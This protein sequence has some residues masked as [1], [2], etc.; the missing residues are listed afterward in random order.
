M[1]KIAPTLKVF[2]RGLILV[3]APLALN[4]TIIG[5]LGYL[6][7]ES[8]REQAFESRYRNLTANSGNLFRLGYEAPLT[9]Y[10]ALQSQE[11]G[12]FKIYDQ[13][14]AL[15]KSQGFKNIEDWRLDPTLSAKTD[16]AKNHLQKLVD[17]LEGLSEARRT[18]GVF[19]LLSSL[20]N[21]SQRMQ[22]VKDGVLE[23]LAGMQELG[24]ARTRA[25]AQHQEAM[26]VAQIVILIL[27]GILNVVLGAVLFRFYKR[28]IKN[29]LETIHANTALLSKGLPMNPR[30]SGDDE[31]SQLD[32]A[33]HSMAAEL[34]ESSEREK[35]LFNNASDVIC[36]LDKQ[37]TFVKINPACF[38][39]WGFTPEELLQSSLQKL[40]CEA[41]LSPTE[42]AI[43]SAREQSI[44]VQFESKTVTK[45]GKILDTL[46]SVYWSN[47][48]ASLYCVV[49]D[50]TERKNAERIKKQFLSMITSDLKVPL[51]SIASAIHTLVTNL[52]GT[53]SE[54][55]KDKLS[56]A[57][58]NVQRLLSLVSDLLQLT[59]LDSGTL[60]LHKRSC[61]VNEILIRAAQDVEGVATKQQVA[62]EIQNSADQWI[63]DEDRIM[64]VL[65]NLLSN[66]IK[67]SPANSKVC[68]VASLEDEMVTVKVIDKGRGVP[69]AH[70]ELIFEKYK[71]VQA[72]DGKR[73]SGTGLGLPICKQIV[74]E[75][76]G[77]IGVDSVE[78]EGSTFWCKLPVKDK[79]PLQQT[80]PAMQ[81]TRHSTAGSIPRISRTPQND[82]AAPVARRGGRLKLS[83]KGALLIGAPTL[84]GVVF[85]AAISMLLFQA[86]Q[87]RARELH[88]RQIV[89]DSN[90]LLQ[91]YLK[92]GGALAGPKTPENWNHFITGVREARKIRADLA[93]L[94][95]G[96]P[97]AEEHYRKFEKSFK[98]PEEYYRRAEEIMA[99]GQITQDRLNK[100][101]SSGYKL[102]PSTLI[103]V[104]KL[105]AL[106][107]DAQVKEFVQPAIQQEIRTKQAFVMI[108]G[109]G[110]NIILS[111][112]LAVYFSKD[113]TS[114]LRILALNAERL[115]RE[116]ELLPALGGEDEIAELDETFHAT[117]RALLESRL[118]ERAVFDNSQ[119]VI[120]ALD[121]EGRF[122]SVNPACQSM[123]MYSQKELIGQSVF[124][125]V[126]PSDRTLIDTEIFDGTRE[127][128]GR[129]ELK[130][131]RKDQEVVW[132]MW[133][134][135]KSADDARVYCV[136]N[137]ITKR[138]ELEQ[139]KQEF[140][141]VVS[142]D[143]R[144]P[145]TSITG[146]AKLI[147]AGAFGKI[148]EAPA[149]VLRA[150]TRNSDK[151]LELINDILDIEKLEAGHMNL[152][153]E[154][155]RV[156][157]LLEKSVTTACGAQSQ[158]RISI[159]SSVNCEIK[160]DRDRL[161]Q[162]LGNILNHAVG[163]SPAESDVKITVR[164]AGNCVEIKVTDSGRTL[165]EEERAQLFA[166]FRDTV[167]TD[168]IRPGT[169][170][171]LPIARKIV[172]SHGGS[173]S[174]HPAVAGGNDFVI[175]LPLEPIASATQPVAP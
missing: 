3:A 40:L 1:T 89:A 166:R 153:L 7:H 121:A 123:W 145:L 158:K 18:G 52:A 66:A 55:A 21:V 10:L 137:D 58:K 110:A 171:A 155:V 104:R 65:V 152:M 26:R 5:A 37:N 83:Y 139:L 144:T 109:L 51:A 94:V 42:Q 168:S 38:K 41:S 100:A 146:I 173:V 105:Q 97:I 148:G 54:N 103:M 102:I 44:P 71:Q 95:K 151:L 72:S 120:F 90:N 59:E 53:I 162:A 170:L 163:F 69:E 150:I 116:E 68:L 141:A 27:G 130:V 108:G 154:S 2:Q 74:E 79:P 15:L 19:E 82:P 172:E 33:F 156:K 32:D 85:V 84:F 70:K 30:L 34:N 77:A 67:F 111:L 16:Q 98:E 4:L 126:E 48:S 87:E 134:F 14:V 124:G 112:L 174:V 64:Q 164:G 63:V 61:S 96:D 60:E 56:V 25:S 36:V 12:L 76:G 169:G 115:A 50:M 17:T 132:V 140:L 23:T 119:D 22:E 149:E 13:D 24:Y 57:Q 73:K 135:S 167:H 46:W 113:I 47:S 128:S 9:L 31:I 99:D 161:I 129:L 78:G 62:V 8:D 93:Q 125:L 92:M 86:G 39:L 157:E 106:L 117:A 118:K 81:F 165:I 28:G 20:P 133:S 101:M 131:V 136:A 127:K 175:R 6:L 49:H 160:A 138:K 143:L 80:S 107:K 142:H 29:R 91:T 11:Q 159:D 43:A 35:A 88:E 45:E 75:H 147:N 114:R 122:V